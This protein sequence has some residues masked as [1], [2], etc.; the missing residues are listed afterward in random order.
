MA[1]KPITPPTSGVANT[2]PPRSQ[3]AAFS[4]PRNMANVRRDPASG[5]I[6]SRPGLVKAFPTQMGGGAMVQGLR[7]VSRA[8]TITDYRVTETTGLTDWQSQPSGL[9]SGQ[10]W[11]LNPNNGMYATLYL[12]V[13]GTGYADNGPATN[14]LSVMAVAPFDP[15][16][17]TL[18]AFA[19]TFTDSATGY[20]VVR[21]IVTNLAGVVQWSRRYDRGSAT[22]CVALTFSPDGLK[23]FAGINDAAGPTGRVYA[24]QARTGEE[25]TYYD[26]NGWASAIKGL[27][28]YRG[29]EGND[30]LYAAFDGIRTAATLPSGIAVDAGDAAQHF[31]AGV[32]K[33]LIGDAT[34]LTQYP[35]GGRLLAGS[36]YFEPD[37]VSA[38]GYHDYW[39]VSEKGLYAAA[40]VDNRPYGCI[41]TGLAVGADGSFAI[42]RTNAGY[43][44]NAS[45]PPD[46]VT[47]TFAFCTVM[48]AGAGGGLQYMLDTDSLRPIGLGGFINDCLVPT[49]LCIAIDAAGNVGTA[50]IRNNTT[51]ATDGF[52]TFVYDPSGFEKF[53]VNLS[54]TVRAIAVDPSSQQFTCAGDRNSDWTGAAGA[55]AHLWKLAT[56]DG[57]VIEHLDLYDQVNA[58]TQVGAKALGFSVAGHT[59]YT[60]AKI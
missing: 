34:V 36:P 43:G 12:D 25:L 37:P 32:M 17:G 41:I 60:T 8:S 48:K 19:S 16:F 46:P 20:T 3:P 51:S 29:T 55:S 21:I 5:R 23:L 11:Y 22:S 13:T 40:G 24:L 4:R 15:S 1:R 2:V 42:C 59:V 33:F 27:G 39:R 50:G 45:F 9:I 53:R 6:R 38:T 44:P 7:V 35:N 58:S 31:R 54:G 14:T 47:G 26:C 10:G 49:L 56:A 28:C 52:T 18:F 30:W 57:T